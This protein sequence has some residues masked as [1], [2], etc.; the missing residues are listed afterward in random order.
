MPSCVVT[1]TAVQIM[2]SLTF[3]KS[4]LLSVTDKKSLYFLHETAV[5]EGREGG[6]IHMEDF[7]L[8]GWFTSCASYMLFSL[9]AVKI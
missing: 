6:V 2:T 8:I 9:T 4:N 3:K 1:G 5:E 7:S